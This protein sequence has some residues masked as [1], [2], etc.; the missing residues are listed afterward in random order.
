MRRFLVAAA[1]LA[2]AACAQPSGSSGTSSTAGSG[3]NSFTPLAPDAVVAEAGDVKITAEEMQK[4]MEPDIYQLERQLF[5]QRHQW[6][7][8]KLIDKLL[9]NEAKRNG[10][11]T[12]EL[13]AQIDSQARVATDADAQMFYKAQGARLKEKD[14]STKPFEFWKDR[15][16][17][18]LND[19]SKN[20]ARQAF[21]G[22]LMEGNPPKFNVPQPEPPYIAGISTDDDP[23]KGPQDAKVT[24]VEFSDFECPA[25]RQAHFQLN[26]VLDKFG[27]QVKFV[28][29][30]FPLPKHKQ[31]LPA[32]VAAHC[33]GEQGKYWEM[34]DQLFKSE[35][36][37][38]D[39]VK[40]I[41][42]KVGVD[43]V[44]FDACLQEPKRAEEVMKDMADGEKYGVN[45]TP[46]FYVNGY[47]VVGANMAEISRLIE[48][49]LGKAG[50]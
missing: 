18:H 16:K 47:L 9:E 3:A 32:A 48:R 31:A 50:S 45:S 43:L 19:Q 46:T 23:A 36:L 2:A 34:H 14:G 29:R 6:L 28:Y 7:Q 8:T 10:K 5:Q 27:S 12:E 35:R 20:G 26:E 21:V 22:K 44:K 49:E 41:A 24:I 38:G 4:G 15:L 33:A 40:N 39:Q 37:D 30:D 13:L 42:G 11:T 17:E 1:L 25:C